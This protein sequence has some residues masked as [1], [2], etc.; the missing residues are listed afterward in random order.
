MIQIREGTVKEILFES[1]DLQELLVECGGGLSKAVC[2]PPLTG[3]A[4]AGDRV[5][6]NTTAVAL[7]LGSGGRHFVIANLSNPVRDMSG[8]GGHIMKLRYTPLQC[9][10]FSAEEEG[11]PHRTA[12]ESFTDLGGVP[13][14]I[15][16]LHSM[17][18][19]VC[20]AMKKLR[21]KIRI[22]YV[23]TDGA[24]LPAAF[25]GTVRALKEKGIIAG[26]VTCGNAFGGDLEAVTKYSALAAARAALGADV[27]VAAMGVG[28]AG[29]GTRLGHTGTEV[30]ELVNAVAALKGRAVVVPRMSFADPRA[31]H[32]GIS[33]HT[34]TALVEIALARATV[35]VPA[36]PE[37]WEKVVE[38]Q[39]VESGITD[40]HD[41]FTADGAVAIEAL[42]EVGMRVTTMGRGP[43]DDP[44]FF[45]A[46]G[47]AAR[48]AIDFVKIG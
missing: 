25:S 16:G 41:V 20:A 34:I 2:Y 9:R 32:A 18:A 1:A 19:P 27:I 17:V 39:L 24:C 44:A 43:D 33:H 23:M 40:K 30:G 45:L 47:A 36:L 28:I 15:G 8:P 48:A 42:C 10:V 6:L 22:V 12:I 46:C 31:R 7:D 21:G 4:S 5:L 29:T 35:A 37:D 26:T 38:K 14:V 13:V 3:R 11:S